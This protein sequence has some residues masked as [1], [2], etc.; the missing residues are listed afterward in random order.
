[1]LS[2]A[3]AVTAA[4]ATILLLEYL[5]SNQLYRDALLSWGDRGTQSNCQK[6]QVS[7]NEVRSSPPKQRIPEPQKLGF[8]FHFLGQTVEKRLLACGEIRDATV[9]SRSTLVSNFERYASQHFILSCHR[10]SANDCV[11]EDS[12]IRGCILRSSGA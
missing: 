8:I 10:H 4:T 5:F 9:S 3:T 6:P 12:R 11:I 2:A 7:R 1:M